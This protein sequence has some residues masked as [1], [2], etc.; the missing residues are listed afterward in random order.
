MP[1][2]LLKRLRFFLIQVILL[3]LVVELFSF[4]TIRWLHFGQPPKVYTNQFLPFFVDN[5]KSF[6]VWHYA[7]ATTRHIGPCWNVEY[8][9]NSYGARDDEKQRASEKK[10][11]LFLGDSFIEGYGID[12][13]K[14]LSNLMEKNMDVECLNFGTSGSFG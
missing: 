6:G 4:I 7:N 2:H 3:V 9:F 1:S 10:R 14:R 5:Y 12:K 13:D 8:Q 11:I